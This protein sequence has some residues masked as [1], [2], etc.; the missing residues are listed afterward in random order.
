[1]QCVHTGKLTIPILHGA[2]EISYWPA[3]H[4]SHVTFIKINC[5]TFLHPKYENFKPKHAGKDSHCHAQ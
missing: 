4:A 2:Q 1:M 5:L 3:I